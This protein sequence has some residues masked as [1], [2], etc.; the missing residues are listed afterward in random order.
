MWQP[1]TMVVLVISLTFAGIQYGSVL[2]SKTNGPQIATGHVG[3][4][5]DDV[6]CT[7]CGSHDAVCTGGFGYHCY[8]CGIQFQCRQRSDGEIEYI[9]DL[10]NQKYGRASPIGI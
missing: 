5:G 6:H 3:H 9:P 7:R 2:C 4:L 8:D 10:R 1:L